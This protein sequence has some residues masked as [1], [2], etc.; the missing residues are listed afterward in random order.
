MGKLAV[1]VQ[2]IGRRTAAVQA[3][4]QNRGRRFD[5]GGGR[6]A[7]DVREADVGGIAAKADGVGQAGIW[8]KFDQELRRTALASETCK[9]SLKDSIAAGNA[10]G[11]AASSFHCFRRTTAGSI[12][13]LASAT[14]EI[15]SVVLSMAS[16]NVS[17]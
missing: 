16:C 9:N 15:A 1:G 2:Q 7:E 8:M 4:E 17:L 13:F 14:P 5:Y 3:A 12:V 11:M 6:A 10:F